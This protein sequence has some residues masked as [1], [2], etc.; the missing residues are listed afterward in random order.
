[1]L[2]ALRTLQ[3]F[4]LQPHLRS[5]AAC[6][7]CSEVLIGEV[8]RVAASEAA[9]VRQRPLC[10][11]IAATLCLPRWLKAA[12]RRCPTRY[13]L[14]MLPQ[15]LVSNTAGPRGSSDIHPAAPNEIRVCLEGKSGFAGPGHCCIILT[16]GLGWHPKAL[17]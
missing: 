17:H 4:C 5:V 13:V 6:C 11:D 7:G 9:M 14:N 8:S 10:R 2:V 16:A 12:Q 15:V 3:L 1:M